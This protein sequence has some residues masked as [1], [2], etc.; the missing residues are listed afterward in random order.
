MKPSYKEFTRKSGKQTS[1]DRKIARY[2]QD[3]I[4]YET[5]YA[6]ESIKIRSIK[7]VRLG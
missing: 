1:L 3:P 7:G 5:G 2:E 6:D 4:R